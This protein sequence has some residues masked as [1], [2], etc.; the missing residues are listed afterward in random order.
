[1]K[2]VSAPAVP[3]TWHALQPVAGGPA[4]HA[5]ITPSGAAQIAKA[6]NRDGRQIGGYLRVCVTRLITEGSR[7]GQRGA[8][9]PSARGLR[10]PAA[11]VARL[12]AVREMSRACRPGRAQA[13]R[14]KLSGHPA[15][16]PCALA[17]L[18]LP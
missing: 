14:N 7:T 10:P 18:L 3:K 1:V 13:R 8:R 12:P 4:S 16:Y 6:D 2:A 15:E 9:L 11:T 5:Q 17:P